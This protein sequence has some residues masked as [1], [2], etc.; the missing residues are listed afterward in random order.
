MKKSVRNALI[1]LVLSVVI[2]LV[3]LSATDFNKSL[4][5]LFNT[6]PLWI[7]LSFLLAIG[8]WF[9]EALTLKI[10]ALMRSLS[11]PFPYLIKITVIG[12]FFNGI[13]PFSSGGQP[14]QILFMQRRNVSVGEATAM[15]VSR[16]LIYQSVVTLLGVVAIFI[17][18]PL[19]AD[20][21]SNLA[22]LS[23]FGFVLN[24][25]VL[26][27]LVFFSLSP[28]FTEKTIRMVVKFL[29]WIKLVKEPATAIEKA[30]RELR[31]FHASMVELIKKP[32]T[33]T[34]AVATTFAQ[35]L[36]MISIPYFVSLAMGLDVD[37][38][39]ITTVQLILFLVISLIPTPGASGV[40]EGGYV[41]FFKP[42]FGQK[43]GAALLI[44]RFFSYYLNILFG[45]LL[46]VHEVGFKFKSRS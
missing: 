28:T 30:S 20:K 8:S 17:A 32:L 35:L 45:G 36:C 21:I 40:S 15:L 1:A 33:I 41:L 24:S 44:W 34:I 38:L 29:H 19:V 5:Y 9:F 39:E 27:F 12:T 4:S 31:F 14:A 42:F 6:N 46:T 10:F 3:V 13:T 7:G 16:F 18:Y 23:F 43:I 26:M 25:V 2:I 37:Y 22:V 11:I